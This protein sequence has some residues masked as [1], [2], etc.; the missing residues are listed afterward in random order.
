M[1]I[2]RAAQIYLYFPQIL[3]FFFFPGVQRPD[4]DP[5]FFEFPH[6]GL[7][8]FTIAFEL[9]S[10]IRYRIQILLQECFIIGNI[11]IQDIP[12]D[13]VHGFLDLLDLDPHQVENGLNVV[14]CFVVALFLQMHFED[15][16]LD[17]ELHIVLDFQG[18]KKEAVAVI[19]KIIGSTPDLF[20]H[21]HDTVCNVT[22]MDRLP[23]HFIKII[24]LKIHRPAFIGEQ[25]VDN[26]VPQLA[27][28][29]ICHGF[30]EILRINAVYKRTDIVDRAWLFL[31]RLFH[32]KQHNREIHIQ[33]FCK[34]VKSELFPDGFLAAS[35]EEKRV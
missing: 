1:L 30:A 27:A 31:Q 2:D 24:P 12:P 16:F 33:L 32:D 17:R 29:L 22:D 8:C 25:A 10:G 23:G 7:H 34:F 5:G 18:P 15:H 28:V 9:I 35:G 3:Q 14:Q 26:K 6:T 21:I 4:I 13:T 11:I 19:C 20:V